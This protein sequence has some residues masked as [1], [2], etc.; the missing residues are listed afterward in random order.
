M[1]SRT[2]PSAPFLDR[3]LLLPEE[4]RNAEL[5]FTKASFFFVLLISILGEGLLTLT[6]AALG[7]PGAAALHAALLLFAAVSVV[8]FRAKFLPTTYT[9]AFVVLGL[10]S[11][12]SAWPWASATAPCFGI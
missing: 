2:E 7:H 6:S 11:S 10:I 9:I 8:F 4:T 3:L 1:T 5:R 12:F